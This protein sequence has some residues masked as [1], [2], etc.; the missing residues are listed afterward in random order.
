MNNLSEVLFH[1]TYFVLESVIEA[2]SELLAATV[3][4]P[5]KNEEMWNNEKLWENIAYCFLNP[6]GSR[7]DTMLR[8][9]QQTVKDKEKKVS[10][11]VKTKGW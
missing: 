7:S 11:R 8:I 9:F 1:A 3:L 6:C 5:K 2:C 4:D 10:G